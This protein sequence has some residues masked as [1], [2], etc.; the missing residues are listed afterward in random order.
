MTGT[1]S[2]LPATSDLVEGLL[3]YPIALVIS[4]TVAPGLTLCIPGLLFATVLILIPL[5][6][7]ALVVVLAAAV[8]AAPV[9]LFRA[10]RGLARRRSASKSRPD[11]AVASTAFGQPLIALSADRGRSPLT[12]SRSAH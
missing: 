8:L 7:M 5:L 11:V 2:E 3:F 4:A 9:V 1:H 6:A 12:S 10:I